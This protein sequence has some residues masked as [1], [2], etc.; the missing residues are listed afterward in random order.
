M[1]EP[2]LGVPAIP[3]EILWNDLDQY[4]FSERSIRIL[5]RCEDF[6]GLQFQSHQL[7][8]GHQFTLRELGTETSI[9]SVKRVFNCPRASMKNAQRNG[10]Q[11]PKQRGRHNV[12]PDD[13]EAHILAWIQHQAEKSQASTRT[14]IFYYCSGKFG[15]AI[16]RGWVDSFLIGH[17]DD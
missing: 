13:S 12:M 6:P 7:F 15:K 5:Q 8:T 3:L 11:P 16:T 4:C 9:G 10:L 17:K 14:D 2:V 1:D